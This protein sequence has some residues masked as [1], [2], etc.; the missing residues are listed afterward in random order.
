[1]EHHN[2]NKTTIINFYSK[3]LGQGDTHLVDSI[4]KDDYIQHSPMVK[5]GK[6]GFVEFLAFLKN[7]PKPESPTKPFF[8]FI[9]E[10]D[11]VAVHLSIEFMGQKKAVMDLFRFE[12]G[13]LA[14]HWDASEDIPEISNNK[15]SVVEGPIN[16]Q[17]P[18]LT[19][20][21]KSIVRTYTNE[22]LIG[23]KSEWQK[24]LSEDLIQHNPEL[25]NGIPSLVSYYRSFEIM[26]IHR[27]IGE[28]NFVATQSHGKYENSSFVVYDIYRL[29]EESIVE[30]WSVKQKIPNKMAHINGM[31]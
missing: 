5:T 3:V 12:N 25:T 14:E 26:N 27:V 30:H 6:A 17:D 1:M 28:G 20:T 29:E 2:I 8:R 7:L 22:V 15:N 24:Y 9:C 4:I 19:N 11:L 21:N 18:G 16:I 10:N 31:I 13:M 23:K